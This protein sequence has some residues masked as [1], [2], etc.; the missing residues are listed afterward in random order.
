ML[1]KVL[2][3][4]LLGPRVII[5]QP[6]ELLKSCYAGNIVYRLI[7]MAGHLDCRIL[8]SQMAQ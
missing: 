2:L 1:G 3:K 5:I 7:F 8:Q 4:S 6:S